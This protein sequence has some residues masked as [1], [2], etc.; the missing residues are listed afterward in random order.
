MVYQSRALLLVN[1]VLVSARLMKSWK[2]TIASN[3]AI[4]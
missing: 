3:A 1:D 2:L 4:D